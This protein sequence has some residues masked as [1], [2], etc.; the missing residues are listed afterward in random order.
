M[1]E[2]G[3]C[4]FSFSLRY[5]H[6]CWPPAGVDADDMDEPGIR[7]PCKKGKGGREA[8]Q[9]FFFFQDEKTE[10][11]IAFPDNQ[12]WLFLQPEA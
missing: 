10:R 1:H 6:T 12:I 2:W 9:T 5:R 11:R 8:C 3:S 4:S 7:A